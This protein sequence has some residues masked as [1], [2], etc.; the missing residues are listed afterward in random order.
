MPTS[1]E[2]VIK[3]LFQ[4]SNLESVY[5]INHCLEGFSTCTSWGRGQTQELIGNLSLEFKDKL[6]DSYQKSV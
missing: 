4:T 3:V 6:K 1:T 5:P 2:L